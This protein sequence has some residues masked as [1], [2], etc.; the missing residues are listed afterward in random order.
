[1]FAEGKEFVQNVTGKRIL[2]G[3]LSCSFPLRMNVAFTHILAGRKIRLFI[4][5]K[6][7]MFSILC[8]KS[9]QSSVLKNVVISIY[10]WLFFRNVTML[11]DNWAIGHEGGK[12]GYFLPSL[13]RILLW[14]FGLKG[15]IKSLRSVG[16]SR[17]RKVR[18]KVRMNIT[19]KMLLR[20]DCSVKVRWL[21]NFVR[22]CTFVLLC[23]PGIR[24]CG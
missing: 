3:I 11:K 18:M 24:K 5:Q 13:S 21:H 15:E 19:F 17:N 10:T 16:V 6:E 4:E 12:K 8:S 2:P 14:A 7:I 20:K 1:M 22:N 9:W 23:Q